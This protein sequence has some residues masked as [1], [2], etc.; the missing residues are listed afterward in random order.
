MSPL[1]TPVAAGHHSGPLDQLHTQRHLRAN[2]T[3]TKT[4][5]ASYFPQQATPARSLGT[6][7]FPLRPD[8]EDAGT[9]DTATRH[10]PVNREPSQSQSQS[11]SQHPP[12]LAASPR[13]GPSAA[14]SRFTED[15]DASRRGSS[16][17]EGQRPRGG[18]D[19]MQRSG[20]FVAGAPPDELQL[21]RANS[22][23]GNTLRKKAS[24]RRSASLKRSGS[25]RSVKAGSV[26]SLA[27]QSTAD[28][29]EAHSAFYCPVPVGA[30]PTDALA[31]RFQAW[32]KYLKELVTY[33]R[34][35]QSHYESR[36][37]AAVKLA[38][39]AHNISHHPILLG[40]DG[41]GDAMHIIRRYNKDAV[42]DAARAQEVEADV[43][44][45][46]SGLRSDL[47]QKIK[48]IK[49]LS[50]DFKNSVEKEMDGTRKAAK[51]LQDVLGQAELD[52]G[53]ATGKQDPYLL[54]L[55]VDRQVE[56]QIDEENY[57]HQ[58]YL[59]LETS[60]RE[61]E[62]IV[63]GEVQKAF[64]AYASILKRE[65]DSAF[66][67]AEE[68]SV[69]PVDMPKDYEW[70]Q[71]MRGNDQFVDPAVPMRSPESIHYPGRDHV[72]CQ[73]LRAGL[74]ERKSKYLKSYTAGWYV[75]SPTH[76]HEFKSA[77]KAQ[78][79]VMSLFL[80]E[81]K[82]GSH[83]KE[84][85]ASQKFI[86]KGR[87]AGG[88]HRGHTWVFRAESYDTMMAWYADLKV[89]TEQTS[90]ERNELF[91]RG[92]SVSTR[93]GSRASRR[94]TSS[95]A[96][97][98]DEE[99]DE[100][101]SAGESVDVGSRQDG[102]A[103]K[104]PQAGGR[105]PSDLQVNDARGGAEAPGSTSSVSSG[106]ANGGAAYMTNGVATAGGKGGDGETGGG[107]VGR[108][109]HG[110]GGYGN[111]SRVR[112]DEAPSHAA[113]V[114]HEAV[115]DGVN[116]YTNEPLHQPTPVYGAGAGAAAAAG[117][118]EY[119]TPSRGH[120]Y[121]DGSVAGGGRGV[122]QGPPPEAHAHSHSHSHSHSHHATGAVPEAQS[123]SHSHSHHATGAVPEA[124]SHSHHATEAVPVGS[125][126]PHGM[127]MAYREPTADGHQEQVGEEK[128]H[129]R[130][131]AECPVVMSAGVVK[132][133]DAANG[134]LGVSTVGWEQPRSMADDEA[135]V[136]EMARASAAK[137]LHV[138]GGYPKSSAA[139]TQVSSA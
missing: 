7:S 46:L 101:F 29:D 53:L 43:I 119:R 138:P 25:K 10:T 115:R 76:L 31:A 85:T 108:A 48:E 89:L 20:S 78:A 110:A 132:V 4:Q 30:S 37:K 105:F 27:L 14:P 139:S 135:V 6:P 125:Y 99:D 51:A 95:D 123:H 124:H 121:A 73:E 55:A 77:D 97:A 40:P 11:Q 66:G 32:R 64:S 79:P 36:A 39:A 116:P 35:V 12:P 133:T 128:E 18:A 5:Q 3:P 82:L 109:G 33:F 71:F 120:S 117:V 62:A 2:T 96:R 47:Q 93:S 84:G 107:Y 58:A 41:L 67:A 127:D 102:G 61:L 112:L 28:P 70:E 83:S 56:R 63:V 91:V 19:T 34:E 44:A 42:Q 86:L 26:R 69:G 104:R 92:G 90:K 103:A 50:G 137:N 130:F 1:Q 45:A 118:Y 68:L 75:L 17:L 8:S 23:G 15:W 98:V 122:P 80:P 106:P 60:G 74:L 16:I 126:L 57:L 21:A 81:Q 100:P 38:S 52:S 65:A 136:S 59:N 54:R 72:A 9:N 114:S 131:S 134:R 94:S 111:T 13:H 87:Q 88:V 24:I 22:S 113:I 49:N 129:V